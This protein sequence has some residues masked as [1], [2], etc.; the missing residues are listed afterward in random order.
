MLT[1]V[2]VLGGSGFV[3]S[4]TVDA[5]L[6]AGLSSIESG[7]PASLVRLQAQEAA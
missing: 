3:G 7:L 6:A 2:F 4:A 5:A 1:D